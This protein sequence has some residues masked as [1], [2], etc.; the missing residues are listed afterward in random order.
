MQLVTRTLAAAEEAEMVDLTHRRP[1][2]RRSSPPPS[3]GAGVNE[4]CDHTALGSSMAGPRRSSSVHRATALHVT[5]LAMLSDVAAASCCYNTLAK[6]ARHEDTKPGSRFVAQAAPVA[7]ADE[8]MKFIKGSSDPKARHNCTLCHAK[9]PHPLVFYA[10]MCRA[11]PLTDYLL[12]G[13][14][15]MNGK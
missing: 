15:R 2:P 6:S 5:L 1:S 8:A 9:F 3:S 11:A 14:V 12:H 7:D 10:W 4:G 13:C